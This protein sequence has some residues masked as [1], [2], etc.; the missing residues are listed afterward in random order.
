MYTVQTIGFCAT[1]VK[2]KTECDR[3]YKELGIQ[4]TYMSSSGISEFNSGWNPP[5]CHNCTVAI[6]RLKPCRANPAMS[7]TCTAMMSTVE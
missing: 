3:A 1:P 4:I 6:R 5:Y 2:T 7:R